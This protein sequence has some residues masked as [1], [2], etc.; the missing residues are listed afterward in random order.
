MC[1]FTQG[2]CCCDL[3]V[4][5]GD[6]CDPD[7]SSEPMMERETW[8]FNSETKTCD[9]FLRAECGGN[10]NDFESIEKCEKVCL[11]RRKVTL[12][13][14]DNGTIEHNIR[15]GSQLAKLLKSLAKTQN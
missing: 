4:E 12:Y 5:G 11:G 13:I 6:V 2:T 8:G 14:Y 9:E 10:C 1:I 3:P 7:D 15:K